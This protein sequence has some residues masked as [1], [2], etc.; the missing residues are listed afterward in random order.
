MGGQRESRPAL[1]EVFEVVLWGYDRDQVNECLHELEERLTAL[2]AEQRRAFELDT[3]LE[4]CRREVA[5]LRARLSGVPVVHQIGTQAAE[6]LVTAERQAVAIRAAAENRL[7]AAEEEAARIVA[8][9]HQEAARAR[10]DCDLVLGEHRRRQQQAADAMLAAARK[11][12]ARLVAAAG[13]PEPA[14]EPEP[15]PEV[16]P[17]AAPE[18]ARSSSAVHD[19]KPADARRAPAAAPAPTPA[20]APAPAPTPAPAPERQRQRERERPV[21]RLRSMPVLNEGTA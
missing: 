3:E 6:I 18:P 5:D 21:G 15:E 20:P 2:Y 12:A 17:Q 7:A 19:A 4:H 9:A 14:T 13:T 10:R 8:A 16:Q 1:A 11:E